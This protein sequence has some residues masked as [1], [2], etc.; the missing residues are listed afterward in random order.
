MKKSEEIRS[1]LSSFFRQVSEDQLEQARAVTGIGYMPRGTLSHIVDDQRYSLEDLVTLLLADSLIRQELIQEK[2]ERIAELE[3]LCAQQ[4]RAIDA[5]ADQGL[6]LRSLLT[7]IDPQQEAV[8]AFDI[9]KN[10]AQRVES[11]DG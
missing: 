4:Q 5:I 9:L 1:L 10:V 8:S 11:R 6:K 3:N 7:R 2:D